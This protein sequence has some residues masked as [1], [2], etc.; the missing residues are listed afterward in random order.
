MLAAVE[1]LHANSICHR[2]LKLENIL[3]SNSSIKVIDFGLSKTSED[4]LNMRTRIG[5]PYYVAPEVIIAASEGPYSLKCD[6]WSVGVIVYFMLIGHPPFYEETDNK[7]FRKIVT[8]D[9]SFPQTDS[10]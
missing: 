10:G 8:C 9:Y 1:Y 4:L 5:T 7:L 6:L 3:L 2:D